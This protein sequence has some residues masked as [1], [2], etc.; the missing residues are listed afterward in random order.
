M[1]GRFDITQRSTCWR[2][3]LAALMLLSCCDVAGA[4]NV[5]R[6]R[7][8]EWRR[9]QEALSAIDLSMP[10]IDFDSLQDV[11]IEPEV[12]TVVDQLDSEDFTQREAAS[13]ALR[14]KDQWRQQIYA[15]LAGETLSVE[16]RCRLLQVVRDQL[17][18]TPR[19]ALGIEM[20]P[21]LPMR[22]EPLEIRIVDLI[23]GLPAERVLQVGDR[24]L[25]I[26]RQPLFLEDDLQSRVQSKR[27]GDAVHV[28]VRRAKVDDN[29]RV[30]KDANDEIVMEVLEFDITLGSA[31]VLDKQSR[32]NMR[33]V[34]N[35]V[36]TAR[37]ME[38]DAVTQA[39]A[40]EPQDVAISGGMRMVMQPDPLD[41]HP[42]IINL[43]TQQEMLIGQTPDQMR[44]MRE[45]WGRQLTDLIDLS[46]HP[47][48]S[49][50][51]RDRMRRLAER[52]A[53]LMNAEP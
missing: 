3:V 5:R 47:G 26:D 36:R 7:R 34:S 13:D 21:L 35:R 30:V 51:E 14:S 24:I 22:G 53:Q 38:A 8:G 10:P 17:V 12:R 50:E 19:G 31:D 28:T 29:G 2:I 41:E 18:N 9:Q 46:N 6:G 4:V 40:P 1:A 16:Q 32:N 43:L 15:L 52:F 11:V 37:R 42:V 45:M 49:P 27:P 23:A 20:A 33:T 44:M 48:L 39:F 25:A